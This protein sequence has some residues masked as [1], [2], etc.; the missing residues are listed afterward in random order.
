VCPE[1]ADADHG[2]HDAHADGAQQPRTLR[3]STLL[4]SPVGSH[5]PLETGFIVGLVR[6][7]SLGALRWQ[8]KRVKK[9]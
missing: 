4:K 8:R 6:E 1:E 9:P 5:H 2:D 3:L 7:Q